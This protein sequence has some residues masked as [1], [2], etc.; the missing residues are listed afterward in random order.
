MFEVRFIIVRGWLILVT[1]F[2]SE[3]DHVVYAKLN[4]TAVEVPTEKTIHQM[5]YEAAAKFPDHIALSFQDV[6][7][8]YEQLNRRSNRVAR[9]LRSQGLKNGDFVA[10]VTERSHETVIGILGILK[11]G[12]VY[13]PIDPSYPDERNRYV[14]VDSDAPFLLTQTHLSEKVN[15]WVQDTSG[16]NTILFLDAPLDEYEEGNLEVGVQSTDLAYVIYTSGSTGRPKGTSIAHLGVV[17][18]GI[19][20]RDCFGCT[21]Q[22]VNLQFA[23]YSFDASVMETWSALFWGGRLHLLAQE[24]RVSI[25][26]FADAV[27]RE[28]VTVATYVPTVFFTQLATYLTDEEYRKLVTLQKIAVGGERMPADAVRLWQRR[29][30]LDIQLFNAYGPTEC[31]V[32]TTVYPIPELG[33]EG[34]TSVLIGRPLPNYELYVINEAN[35]LCPVNEPGELYIGGIGL[36]QGYLCQPEKTAEVFVPHPFSPQADAVLYRSGDLVRLLPDGNI[37]CIGRKDHQVKINGFRIELG[38]IDHVLAQYPDV[39]VAAV[40]VRRNSDDNG[41]LV[42]Y[43]STTGTSVE[44]EQ[45]RQFVSQKLPAHMI[46]S[47]FIELDTMPLSP[48]GKIDRVEL[49]KQ[50]EA[51]WV[52]PS[53]SYEPPASLTEHTIAALWSDVLGYQT[54]SVHDH[55]FEVGGHSL[56]A[57]RLINK[58]KKEMH[59]E[60]G[61]NTLFDHPTLKQLAHY[62][63]QAVR[64][65]QSGSVPVISKAPEQESYALSHTQK[66]MWF[67][68]QVDPTNGAYNTPVHVLFRGQLDP[69][70]LEQAIQELVQRHA[71]LRTIFIEQSGEPRQVILPTCEVRLHVEDLSEWAEEQQAIVLVEKMENTML[72]PFD[73]TTG[74]LLRVELYKLREEEFHLH[75]NMHHIITDGWS[76][77]VFLNELVAV[78][79]ARRESQPS[80]LSP[81]ELQYVDYA[82]WQVAEVKKGRWEH[83]CEYWLKNLK[84]PLPVLELP[85]DFSR[86]AVQSIRGGVVQS[87]L[88]AEVT[89]QLREIARQEDLSLFMLLLT[90][91]FMLLHQFTQQEDIL[92]G[93]PAAG[94]TVDSL[95]PLIGFFANSLAIRTRF[96]KEQTLQDVLQQ[97]KQ[98]CLDAYQNQSYPFDLLVEQLN[99]ERD[100]SRSPIFS[101]MFVF[102]NDITQTQDG[103]LQFETVLGDVQQVHSK[104]DLTLIVQE[105]E[106]QL[107]AMFEF[108]TDLF[109]TDT[110][111]RFA[112]HWQRV[113][114]SFATELPERIGGLDLLTEG[115]RAL[116]AQVNATEADVP[117]GHSIVQMFE[118]AAEKYADR[119]ALSMGEEVLT[120]AQLNK[121]ANQ[122]AH[123]LCAQ[124]TQ[125][126][127][128][129]AILM[130]RSPA[131]VIGLLGAMKAG[132]AYIPID[133]D[134]PEEWIRYVLDDSKASYVVTQAALLSKVQAWVA[135]NETL[136]SVVC[137][138]DVDHYPVHDP[139]IE[140]QAEDLAYLL[141]T[142]GSTGRPKGTLVPHR[143]VVNLGMWGQRECR[144]SET[145]T[146][147]QFAS[148]SFD[149][150][151]WET[152][153]ALFWGARLHLLGREERMSLQAFSKAV[154]QVQATVVALPT[155]FFNQLATYLSE[156]E[157]ARLRS[158]KRIIVAGERLLG[159]MVRLWQRRFGLD[160]VV[161]NAYGPTECTVLSVCYEVREAVPEEQTGIPIGKPLANYQV[162]VRNEAGQ[163]CPIG[164]PGE[165][166]IG[167]IGVSN[168]YLNQPEKTAEAFLPDLFADATDAKLYRS[169]DVV[170]LRSDGL[171]EYIGRKDNQVKVRGFRIE[172]Q[173]IEETLTKH[174]QVQEAAV[175]VKSLEGIQT[176]IAYY[177]T[178]DVASTSPDELRTFVEQRLPGFMVPSHIYYLEQMPINSSGKVNRKVLSE[179]VDAACP[180]TGTSLAPENEWQEHVAQ[181]WQQVLGAAVGIEDD[182]F[183]LGGNSLAVLKALVLLKADWPELKVQDFF[184]YRTIAELDKHVSRGATHPVE[185]MM[186]SEC[187]PQR[188]VVAQ[189]EPPVVSQQFRIGVSEP[190]GV[191]LT[192]ATGYLGAHVLFELFQESEAHLYCLVRPS[193][194]MSAWE[195]LEEAVHFYFGEEVASAIVQRVTVLEG[196]LGKG[197]LGLTDEAVALIEEEVDAIVHCGADVRHFG[198]ASH[199]EN[200]NVRATAELLALARRKE[201][202]RFHYVSTLSVPVYAA[203]R[204][205]VE[206]SKLQNVYV[207][208]KEE[209]ERLV[210]SAMAD[211]MAAAVYRVGNLVCHAQT[212]QFQRNMEENAFYRSI[213][214]MLLLGVTADGNQYVDMT[215]IDYASR[216][217][218][219]LMLQSETA[220]HTFHLCHPEPVEYRDFAR[221][222]REVGYEVKLM[223]P[224][225]YGRWLEQEMRSE[226]LLGIGQL[227]VA[228]SE[229]DLGGIRV[230]YGCAKTQG[231]LAELDVQCVAI[232]RELVLQMVNYAAK[233]GYFPPNG[234][235]K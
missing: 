166:Y 47:R 213:R 53:R 112:E 150:S 75:L 39:E 176:L 114:R 168:G 141:Y 147:L 196:D 43:Y 94:R 15:G 41:V 221:L 206:E 193:Q 90:A 155:A 23:S 127:D 107:R 142:S 93:I 101:T 49:E 105:H 42:A 126:G 180:H 137:V 212:G 92:V 224:Q 120:Y 124:G 198:E 218:V 162:Y 83:E 187:L 106:G 203:M 21:E 118:A 230:R 18:L 140:V 233:V 24:E 177:T 117:K 76:M 184:Q 173:E 57:M 160:V 214:A 77:N 81:L 209:S 151:V 202:I 225:A 186:P 96:D 72:I 128:F 5:F 26:A 27:Q 16:E 44:E 167:G 144:S 89:T 132:G 46:P 145:D 191:L 182:F 68:N 84:Y 149:A 228:Q 17:N 134:Y 78:Y 70:C 121:R 87:V 153:S 8:T 190:Q 29:F 146:V 232:D 103:T 67:L 159:E 201:G 35:E 60:V 133:P 164:V 100:M 22:A 55:F 91:Y 152:W 195:R 14:L 109:R 158:L 222:F 215:P 33:A 36:A 37:E 183:A 69:V 154:Q 20:T 25:E 181:V 185:G 200:V 51:E 115:D 229:Y 40:I 30:G 38:E 12:G 97:V 171:L 130:E 3:A 119:V 139:S 175:L 104:F 108:N 220:G 138:Q 9:L 216:A 199:F 48:N 204:G 231:M 2:L 79:D 63:D 169:G 113:V 13:I 192:G 66:R 82:E 210:R 73:L 116:Y 235:P 207:S 217:L 58:V 227:L 122:V 1:K 4:G 52:Q 11:A 99:P 208:S 28:Q 174:P 148:Y 95:E 102:Q 205:L 143:G 110:V 131:T 157:Y 123:A 31:T 45:L 54:V 172:M 125:T 10:L 34:P 135:G 98:Q 197:G 56:S 85:L 219:K 19:W 234:L 7:L 211:G 32:V 65:G 223:E 86:P 163:T 165:L 156:E 50:G 61:L 136:Q 111:G 189:E 129:V 170:R 59:V 62:I 178:V 6:V 71:T 88:P 64:G 161:W 179:R 188:E 74:P 194:E 80:P 226:E